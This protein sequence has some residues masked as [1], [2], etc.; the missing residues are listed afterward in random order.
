MKTYKMKCFKS[1]QRKKLLTTKSKGQ[2]K[3]QKQQRT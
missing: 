2:K 1:L 3:K